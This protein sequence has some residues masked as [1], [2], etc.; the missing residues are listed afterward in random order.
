MGFALLQILVAAG[1][2][3]VGH[4]ADQMML[5][6]WG[7]LTFSE[8]RMLASKPLCVCMWPYLLLAWGVKGGCCTC[9]D[10]ASPGFPPSAV[11][12]IA[13]FEL[14][15]CLS[16]L[17]FTLAVLF[18]LLAAGVESTFWERFA[19]WWGLVVAGI[20]WY[21]AA[22]DTINEQYKRVSAT[23]MPLGKWSV[24]VLMSKSLK[25]GMAKVPILGWAYVKAC[26][27]EDKAAGWGK[28]KK[29]ADEEAGYPSGPGA[30]ALIGAV[31]TGVLARRRRVETQ[32]LNDKLRQINAELRRQ[33]EQ[34]ESILTAM[35]GGL[36][37][38]GEDAE[39]AAGAEAAAALE[40]LRRQEELLQ[41][42]RSFLEA[43]MASPSAAHPTEGYGTERLSLA[44][45]RRRIAQC[46]HTSKELVRDGRPGD[47]FPLL[48]EGLQLARE[49]R[50]VRA[51]R[52]LVRV[53]ARAHRELGDPA[54]A[55][56]D[57]HRSMALSQ[58]LGETD[59]RCRTLWESS[60]TYRCLEAIANEA[61]PQPLSS[62]W[63][64]C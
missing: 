52:A 60:R 17:F 45:T 31:V 10:G 53:R 47:T 42:E 4:N 8:W 50:D 29:G 35:G 12:M 23:V 27:R 55:L 11:F 41:Q 28:A 37:T 44:Q 15:F 63:D 6:L 14:N 22:A 64:A 32:T 2:F 9:P 59:G 26:N 25:R 5:S 61:P 58:Q 24:G 46:I 40:A 39:G 20:A 48:A 43:A 36:P 49:T 34:Q 54:A 33:R 21:I 13:T 56:Q 16:L 3:S 19:G 30:A 7:I 57:L 18:W 62:T 1:L 51:E 38:P